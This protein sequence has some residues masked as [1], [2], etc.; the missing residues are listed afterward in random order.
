VTY[1]IHIGTRDDAGWLPEV[2]QEATRSLACARAKDMLAAS[3]HFGAE[4][5]YRLRLVDSFAK[6]QPG[7]TGVGIPAGQ[8][9]YFRGIRHVF[10]APVRSVDA[11]RQQATAA[12]D[13]VPIDDPDAVAE[14]QR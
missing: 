9:R 13:A 5:R 10:S 4:V 1:T 6:R 14:P 12:V 11:G 2:A 8:R 3:P 7:D